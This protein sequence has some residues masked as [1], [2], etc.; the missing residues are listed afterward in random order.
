MKR[1]HPL[2]V[3]LIDTLPEPGT[4]WPASRRAKWLQTAVNIFD[5]VYEDDGGGEILVTF[6][7]P[8]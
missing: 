6:Q 5:L 8:G 1:L 7:E 2:L 4:P 3:G